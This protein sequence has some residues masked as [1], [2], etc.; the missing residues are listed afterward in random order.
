MYVLSFIV[1]AAVAILA[2][3]FVT[4]FWMV[5]QKQLSIKMKS[6]SLEVSKANK[7]ATAGTIAKDAFLHNV[8]HQ[9]R[10][11]LHA[12]NGFAQLLSSTEYE[13]SEEEKAEFASHIKLNTT[14]LMKLFDDILSV[15]DVE[16]GKFDMNITTCHVNEIVNECLDMLK[17]M[18]KESVELSYESEVDDDFTMECDARRL[19]QVL[20]N[21]LINATN[22]TEEGFIKVEARLTYDNQR[23]SF[24]VTDSGVGIPEEMVNTIIARFKKLEDFSLGGGIGL[25]LCKAIADR[26]HGVFYLDTTYPNVYSPTTHGARFICTLPI[27]QS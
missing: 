22:H 19:Q 18:T 16:C 25:P 2:I 7:E 1:L 12:I 4:V 14:L 26:L 11:P 5:K 20:L 13:F 15:V 6:L 17:H 24:S 8:S 27:N 9:I 23:I 21:L 3:A 10:T